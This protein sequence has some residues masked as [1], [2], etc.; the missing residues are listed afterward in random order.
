M[1]STNNDSSKNAAS[2]L[3]AQLGQLIED[4]KKLN[5]NHVYLHELP[6]DIMGKINS[7]LLDKMIKIQ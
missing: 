5:S 6:N 1:N 2:K 4:D 7:R 3:F